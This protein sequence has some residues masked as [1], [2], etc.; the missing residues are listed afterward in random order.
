MLSAPALHGEGQRLFFYRI[1]CIR[2]YV[3]LRYNPLRS[4][5]KRKIRDEGPAFVPMQ[6]ERPEQRSWTMDYYVKLADIALS[7]PPEPMKNKDE[8]EE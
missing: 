4:M 2:V 7:I 3:G 1:Y 6:D 5:N 8:E